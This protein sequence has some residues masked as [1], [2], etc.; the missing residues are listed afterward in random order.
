MGREQALDQTVQQGL[1]FGIDPMQILT[2]EQQRVLLALTLQHPPALEVVRMHTLIN[3]TRF[4]D[5]GFP[6]HRHHLAVTFPGTLQ[7]LDKRRAFRLPADK[8]RQA[9][10]RPGLESTSE[11]TRPDQLEDLY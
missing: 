5:P 2:D 11:R 3:Q 7:G 4:P 9:L 1:G 8:T 6:D 10:C